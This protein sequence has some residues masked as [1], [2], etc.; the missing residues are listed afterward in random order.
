MFAKALHEIGEPP[1]SCLLVSGNLTFLEFA[2]SLG[3]KTMQFEGLPALQ[4]NL[5]QLIASEAP[6][7]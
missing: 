4:Q 5:E 3:L 2:L 7:N 6:N 1:E